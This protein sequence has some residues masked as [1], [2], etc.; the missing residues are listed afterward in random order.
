MRTVSPELYWAVIAAVMTSLLW[1]PHILQ[2]IAEMGFYEA[3]RDPRH[4]QPTRAPWAQRAIRAHANAVENLVVFGL[5]AVVIQIQGV[6][7]PLTAA[8]AA[9]Y[10]AA[11]AGHYLV[12]V[13]GLPWL[14]TPLFLGGFVCQGILAGRILGFW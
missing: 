3:F 12:Y 6:S 5:F 1:V 11:R 2:R 10:V 4:D 14:R 13:L 8:A 7:G 9:G